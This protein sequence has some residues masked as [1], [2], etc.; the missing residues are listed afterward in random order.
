[1]QFPLL[2]VLVGFVLIIVGG[3]WYFSGSSFPLGRL[4][5]DVSFQGKNWKFYFPLGTSLLISIILTLLFW[6][7]AYFK[8]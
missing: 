3:G 8:K 6:V 7:I 5:G 4:P 1:M 2:L